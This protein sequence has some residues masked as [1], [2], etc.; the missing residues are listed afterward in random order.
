MTADG[1]IQEPTLRVRDL[2]T[3]FFTKAGIVKAVDGISFDVHPGKVLGLVGES[4]SGKT[5]T[6]FSILGLVDE[7]G[8]IVEGDIISV[9]YT[10]LTLPTILRV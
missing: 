1:L 10:H 2:K 5:V 6:G 4:G 8:R 3:Q 7:P 9:S